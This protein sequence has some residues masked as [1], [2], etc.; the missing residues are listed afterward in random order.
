MA[1]M[2]SRHALAQWH[3]RGSNSASYGE[4]RGSAGPDGSWRGGE[5]HTRP[6]GGKIAHFERM[7]WP[8]IPEPATA[9]AALTSGEIDWY[10][11][12]QPD[13]IPQLRRNKDIRIGSANPGGFNGILRFNHMNTPFNNVAIRRA[14]MMAV[15]QP[16]YMASITGNDPTAYKECKAMFPCGTP[17]GEEIG[18]EVMLDNLDTMTLPADVCDLPEYGWRLADGT[19]MTH[20]CQLVAT[21]RIH[22]QIVLAMIVRRFTRAR[23]RAVMDTVCGRW[24]GSSDMMIVETAGS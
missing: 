6:S 5:V 17:Y 15:D 21:Q 24:L 11:Q 14:V 4:G 2:R 3:Q 9:A 13:L 8:T 22:S 12:V 10:E 7:E 16:E 19:A 23:G 1:P 18:A 20:S